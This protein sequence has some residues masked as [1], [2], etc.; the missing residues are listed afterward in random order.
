MDQS[1]E[2]EKIVDEIITIIEQKTI[3]IQS[4]SQKKETT[5]EKI[6]SLA[7]TP[8]SPPCELIDSLTPSNQEI[9]ELQKNVGE[10]ENPD[11]DD[12]L[13]SFLKTLVIS[14][15]LDIRIEVNEGDDMKE[16]L[17][18]KANEVTIAL[19][20]RWYEQY[21]DKEKLQK[22][23]E[24][25][26]QIFGVSSDEHEEADALYSKIK[27]S[28][29]AFIQ[30]NTALQTH[31]QKL[32]QICLQDEDDTNRNDRLTVSNNEELLLSIEQ[33]WYDMQEKYKNEKESNASLF[34]MLE[35]IAS[36]FDTYI[37]SNQTAQMESDALYKHV[38]SLWINLKNQTTVPSAPSFQSEFE[39]SVK[40]QANLLQDIHK[41]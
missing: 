33:A 24:K 36:M 25:I 8:E 5:Q 13:I 14:Y 30:K 32:G 2:I 41:S 1:H 22:T 11:K 23:V 27:E 19:Q 31:V 10:K 18:H 21:N 35:N 17:A 28:W 39:Q 9:I 38:K 4:E 26:A 15:E 34:E 16:V 6:L 12:L 20:R 40:F 37:D 7:K 29:N 3:E